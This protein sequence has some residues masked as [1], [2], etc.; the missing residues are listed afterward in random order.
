MAQDWLLA[1]G[2]VLLIEGIVPFVAPALWRETV[3]R[4]SRMRDGQIR[5]F[6][7]GALLVGLLLVLA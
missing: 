3:L 1:I 4:V 2:L 6:G 7:L 5:F